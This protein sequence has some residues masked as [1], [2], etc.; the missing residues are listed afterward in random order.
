MQDLSSGCTQEDVM[1][2]SSR[3]NITPDFKQS[4]PVEFWAFNNFL[5][6]VDRDEAVDSGVLTREEYLEQ[7]HF[8]LVNELNKS[9]RKL[10]ASLREKGNEVKDFMSKVGTLKA[11][12]AQWQTHEPEQVS[13]PMPEAQLEWLERSKSQLQGTNHEEKWSV[14]AWPENLRSQTEQTADVREQLLS[15]DEA[16]EGKVDC[17]TVEMARLQQQVPQVTWYMFLVS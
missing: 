5:Q 15:T 7:E 2:E 17:L 14:V 1:A 4:G 16:S 6:H 9:H 13:P 3:S 10:E 12:M 8:A 11:Q